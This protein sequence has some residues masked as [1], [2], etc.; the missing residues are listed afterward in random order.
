MELFLLFLGYK[1]IR[2]VNTFCKQQNV[3][4]MEV[5]FLVSLFLSPSPFPFIPALVLDQ[6]S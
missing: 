6:V 4:E 5:L 3:I 2:N 1:E